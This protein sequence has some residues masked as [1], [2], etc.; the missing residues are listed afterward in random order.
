MK[1]AGN[2]RRTSSGVQAYFKHHGEWISKHFATRD[3]HSIG[4]RDAA[5][6]TWLLNAR[7]KT[8]L[9]QPIEEPTGPSFEDDVGSYLDAVTSMPSYA[10]RELHIREW[11]EHFMGRDRNSIK[12]IEIRT[13]LERLIADGYRPSSVNKRRTALMSFYTRMNGKSGYNPVRDVEKYPEEEEPRALHP[14]T[15]YRILAMMRPS[16]TRARLRVILTTGWPHAQLKR[17]KPE[18]LDLKNARA[19]VTPRRK[20]KGKK[21]QW[22]PLL[23]SAVAAL[24]EFV[25]WDCFTPRDEQG[26]PQPFSNSAMHSAF[27]RAADKLNAHRK[28]LK[29]TPLEVRPYDFRHTFGTWIAGRITDDRAIQE[30]L[31]HAT[32]QQ[33]RRYTEQATAGR[34]DRALATLQLSA[35]K[36]P[37]VSSVGLRDKKAKKRGKAEKTR[38]I[39]RTPHEPESA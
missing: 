5:A 15:A 3:Y 38:T 23:P 22:L 25:A 32:I 1:K 34:V 36:Y 39:G 12:P 14:F 24:R 2:I 18:H 20:G 37:Q 19:Y 33:Q 30:L 31:M 7:A 26:D 27:A 16:K 9:N 21:G 28:R 8:Q 17:L 6:R 10:D 29:L 13:R 35:P 4:E 11:A